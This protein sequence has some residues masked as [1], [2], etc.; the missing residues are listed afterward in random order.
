MSPVPPCPNS[1]LRLKLSGRCVIVDKTS[2]RSDG[3]GITTVPCAT[4]SAPPL[5]LVARWDNGQPERFRLQVHPPD[6]SL[7]CLQAGEADVVGSSL[8]LRAC[9][10]AGRSLL[11]HEVNGEGFRLS[12]PGTSYWLGSIPEPPYDLGLVPHGNHTNSLFNANCFQCPGAPLSPAVWTLTVVCVLLA[13][14]LPACVG[15]LCERRHG[16]ATEAKE[17]EPSAWPQRRRLGGL[18]GLLAQLGWLI[19]IMAVTPLT[20]WM[21]ADAWPGLNGWYLALLAPGAALLLLLIRPT[22][23]PRVLG[24]LYCCALLFF[25]L[26]SAMA[27]VLVFLWAADAQWQ[28]MA[29]DACTCA[30]SVGSLGVLWRAARRTV[31][32]PAPGRVGDSAAALATFRFVVRV[33][34]AVL[35]A[36]WLLH[37]SVRVV[38]HPNLQVRNPSLWA[39]VTVGVSLLLTATLMRYSW[40]FRL[41]MLPP[42]HSFPSMCRN[43]QMHFVHAE[44]ALGASPLSAPPQQ[45]AQQQQEAAAATSGGSSP[46]G[47]NSV[48]TVMSPTQVSLEAKLAAED[49]L[50]G[51]EPQLCMHDLVIG[52]LAQSLCCLLT[53]S[54]ART[55]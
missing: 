19:I 5:T 17:S 27:A 53:S 39:D 34:A 2:Q 45:L 18:P 24:T 51:I 12:V 36:L 23:P 7:M 32:S 4:G 22:D 8:R 6:G 52:M 15:L 42:L 55:A 26:T 11:G 28:L 40:S 37:K 49:W 21:V 9:S 14:A 35:G 13:A 3:V 44:Q 47:N 33:D 46:S 25:S 20:L 29:R 38:Q 16:H 43:K 41:Q 48:A 31:L 30:L 54:H 50:E 1:C 10:A